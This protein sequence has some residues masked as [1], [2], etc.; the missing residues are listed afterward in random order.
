MA[1]NR[2]RRGI[3]LAW[4]AIFLFV[5]I[6]M[7]GLSIDWG[8][9][10]WNVHQMQNAADAGALAGAQVVK[11][12]SA[13]PVTRTHY[14]ALQNWA[15]QLP[16]TL[17]IPSP[18]QEDPLV[19]DE[20]SY[21]ILVGRWVTYNRTF[22]PTLDAPNAVKAVARRNGG[23]DA[24]A[25]ALVFGPIFGTN[26]VNAV[27]E[28]VAW[29]NDSGGSGLICL[30][31]SAVP[32]LR[33]EGG[34]DIDVEGGGIHVNSTAER[35]NN[36][37]GTWVEGNAWL[38][39]GFINTVGS[40]SPSPTDA[41]GWE[42]V[43]PTGISVRDYT[44]GVERIDDP[45]AVTMA[46]LNDPYVVYNGTPGVPNSNPPYSASLDLP[47]LI[48][49]GTFTT[50]STATISPAN[51]ETITLQPGYYPGGI[52]LH[53]AGTVILQPTADFGAGT[54]FIF[55]GIGL[56]VT[57]GTLRGEGVTCYVT[58]NFT[59]HEYGTTNIN[60]G[61]AILWSPGD[62]QNQK[63]VEA[64]PSAKPDLS[65]VQGL[66]GIALWQDPMMP[67]SNGTTDVT[68]NGNGGVAIH[69]TVYF[70]DPIRVKLDGDLGQA[71]NQIICGSADITG[72]AGLTVPYDGRNSPM[73]SHRAFLVK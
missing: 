71:G 72:R 39:C 44:D 61:A 41:G 54:I 3:A 4:T 8:K 29:C 35:D 43:A 20:S 67:P 10:V 18:A 7:V 21:D 26:D 17:Q 23:A 5:M 13:D 36:K 40:V 49:N 11:D 16:V 64:D 66:D 27:R 42:D 51:G 30:S 25:L 58:E 15:D 1:T 68:L 33:I 22:V 73:Q 2:N 70:P 38:D 65:L 56:N 46:A 48:D 59:T 62:W 60:G 9:C 14:F 69:G 28:A 37:G 55:G 50:R 6:G 34:A 31:G 57:G 19:G 52:D 45:V 53:N 47:T 12:P 24:P 63:A 32:G